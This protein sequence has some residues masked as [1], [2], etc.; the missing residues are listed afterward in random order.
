L[1]SEILSAEHVRTILDYDPLTGALTWRKPPNM[2]LKVGARAGTI[3]SKNGYR[4]IRINGRDYLA[5]RLAWLHVHGVW[6][7]EMLDHINRVRSDNRIANLRP[8]DRA[9]NA[10]NRSMQS[11][12]RSGINGVSW[13]QPGQKWIAR[14]GFA[15]EMKY[16]GS[17]TTID[18]AEQAYKAAAALH[19]RDM[20][21]SCEGLR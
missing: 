14:I 7:T 8:A 20:Q 11:N 9:L 12:N 6:P 21:S 17:F 5:H 15:G 1:A 4:R 10:R 16:L 18:A 2:R 13:H 19:H 3:S